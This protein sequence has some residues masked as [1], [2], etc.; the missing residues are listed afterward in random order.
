MPVEIESI[1]N[2][3]ISIWLMIE[4]DQIMYLGYTET[5]ICDVPNFIRRRPMSRRTV[6]K[7]GSIYLR[8]LFYYRPEIWMTNTLIS[9]KLP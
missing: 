2:Y 4:D 5:N 7:F 1:T 6:I 8:F 9:P 3:G